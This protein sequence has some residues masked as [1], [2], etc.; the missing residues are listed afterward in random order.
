MR[1]H[2][3]NRHVIDRLPREHP[4]AC[5]N[6]SLDRRVRRLLSRARE[7][8]G[9]QEF[10]SL[11]AVKI[12]K[13]LVSVTCSGRLRSIPHGSLASGFCALLTLDA[14]LVDFLFGQMFDPDENVLR[15]AGTDDLIELHLDGSTIP[16]L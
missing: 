6:W 9:Q 10:D 14:Q 8:N 2:R 4:D 15:R 16:V 7:G 5:Y 1:I 12:R 3:D 13:T 11:I